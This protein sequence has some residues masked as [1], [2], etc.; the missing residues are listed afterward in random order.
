MAQTC[1]YQHFYIGAYLAAVVY[2][3]SINFSTKQVDGC[4]I[5]KLG[6]CKNVKLCMRIVFSLFEA[7]FIRNMHIGMFLNIRPSL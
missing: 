7:Y 2:R 5:L 1:C 4:W 6:V 3:F